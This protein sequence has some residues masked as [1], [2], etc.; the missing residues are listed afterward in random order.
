MKNNKLRIV[1]IVS[2]PSSGLVYHPCRLAIAF[3]RRGHEVHALKWGSKE[4]S[5]GLKEDLLK[6]GVTVHDQPSLSRYGISALLRPSDE[7]GKLFKVL[8]PC[9]VHTYG[10]VSAFQCRSARRAGS[11]IVT[12]IEAMGHSSNSLLKVMFGGWLLNRYCDQVL[13]LCMM[14]RNRLLSAGVLPGK[15]QIVHN[16]LDCDNMIQRSQEAGPRKKVLRKLGLSQDRRYIGCLASFQPRKRQDLLI[17]AFCALADE[18]TE[19][20]LILAGDGEEKIACDRMVQNLGYSDRIHFTGWL[21]TV[22]AIG[23]LSALDV[24]AHCSNAETFGY[25]MIEP[26]LLGKPTV[27]T[28]VAIG[29]E[30]ERDKQAIVVAPNSK[31]E[32]VAGLRRAIEDKKFQ[33]HAKSTGRQYIQRMFDVQ[34]IAKLLENTYREVF[35]ETDAINVGE[36]GAQTR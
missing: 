5:P 20:D 26:I 21:P 7:L 13:A 11:R 8:S 2:D 19:W 16:H 4:Q 3:A 6:A 14:E 35:C 25:S 17:Q 34:E 23:L 15:L 10:P 30:L 28:K 31:G 36:Q 18:Y 27:V 24:V 29:M 9:I 33:D 1:I 32:L 22:D 12:M